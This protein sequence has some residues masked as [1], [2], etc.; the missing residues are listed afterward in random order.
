MGQKALTMTRKRSLAAK[1]HRYVVSDRVFNSRF[2][3]ASFA[4]TEIDSSID[5]FSDRLLE[6]LG[7]AAKLAQNGIESE[8]IEK[9]VAT[10]MIKIKGG[11]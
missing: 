11:K 2:H 8:A 5:Y 9:D 4:K 1:F 6:L 3:G 10:S 7:L